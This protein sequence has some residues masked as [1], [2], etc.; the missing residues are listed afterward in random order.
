LVEPQK[1]SSIWSAGPVSSL[2]AMTEIKLPGFRSPLPEMR[3][4]TV[5]DVRPT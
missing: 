5:R 2:A 4:A 3:P 1:E